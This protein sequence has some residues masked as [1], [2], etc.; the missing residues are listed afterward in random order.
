L[1]GSIVGTIGSLFGGGRANG[2][3]VS[4]GNFYAVNETSTAPGLFF[5]LA[6]GR[7]EPPGNDNGRGGLAVV[8]LALSADLDARIESISGNMAVEVQRANAPAVVDAAVNETTRVLTRG[9]I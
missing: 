7:I 3:P 9:S 5:P 1:I 2:G 6:P 8:R 4:P